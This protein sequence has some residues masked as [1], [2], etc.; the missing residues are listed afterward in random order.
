[1]LRDL[2]ARYLNPDLQRPIINT[3]KIVCQIL[4]IGQSYDI[5]I[6]QPGYT[7]V[8]NTI[9]IEASAAR[10]AELERYNFLF[11]NHDKVF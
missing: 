2:L 6:L 10:I 9:D 1:M 7:S 5:L 11:E 4:I 3:Q 8:Y